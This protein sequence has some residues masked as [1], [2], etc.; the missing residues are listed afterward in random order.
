MPLKT[1]LDEQ[2]TLNLTSMMDVAFLLIFFFMVSTQFTESER[3]IGLKVPE[4]AQRAVLTAAPQKRIVNVYRDGTL[5]LDR[6]PVTL[7]ELTSRL[8]AAR[9]HRAD[10]GV[11]V[12]GDAQ[13]QFQRVAE[14]LHACKEAGIAELGISVRQ[15][16]LRR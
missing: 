14:V 2:P 9:S 6:T 3:K 4:V 15:V 1:H 8:A 7:E 12:R 5:S 13:G 10:V 16:P 11:L